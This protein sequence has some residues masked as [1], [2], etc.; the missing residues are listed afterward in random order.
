MTLRSRRVPYASKQGTKSEVAHK[1]AG[2]YITPA[3][4]GVPNASQWGTKTEVPHMWAGWV[5]N[6]V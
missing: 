4:W 2:G 1:W 5:Y 6:P 3:V